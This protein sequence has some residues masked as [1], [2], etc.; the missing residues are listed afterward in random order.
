VFM[1]VRHNVTLDLEVSNE[2]EAF[3]KELGE[4]KSKI[5]QNALTV[6]FDMLDIKL[7][8]K[9]LK[10]LKRGKARQYDAEEVWR[11]LELE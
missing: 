4:K 10:E 5:I 9:R 2:L 8:K 7:A 1:Q 3:T 11:T 6:F